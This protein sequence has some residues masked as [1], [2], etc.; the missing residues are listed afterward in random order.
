ML[1]TSLLQRA[2]KKNED[3]DIFKKRY[4]KGYEK[5][6]EGSTQKDFLFDRK[7]IGLTI[8]MSETPLL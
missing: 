5:S 4:K 6:D 3:L 7:S 1:E 2:S 8:S